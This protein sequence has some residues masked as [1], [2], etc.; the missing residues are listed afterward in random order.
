MIANLTDYERAQRYLSAAGPVAEGG[1]NNA[2][3]RAGYALR[4]NFP[5]LTRWEFESLLADHARAYSP[6]LEGKEVEKTIRSAWQGAESKGVVGAK[7]RPLAAPHG[8]LRHGPRPSPPAAA[9]RPP[10][11]ALE[12]PPAKID[13]A[14]AP[15]RPDPMADGARAFLAAMFAPEEGV[16]ICPARVDDNGREVPSSE[17]T[18]LSCREWLTRLERYRGNPNL[19]FSSDGPGLFVSV[20]PMRL[21]GSRDADVT[22]Y[23]HALL[24]FDK[25]SLDEQWAILAGS[26][27]PL[28]AVTYSGGKSI[29]GLVK[30]NARDRREFDERVR[31]LYAHFAAYLPDEACRNASRFS[32]LPGA[33]R[34]DKRQELLALGM[35]AAGW[36]EWRAEVQADGVGTVVRIEDLEKFD[37]ANDPNA[38]LGRRWLCKGGSA[39]LVG[40]SGVGKSSLTTQFACCL[41]V[42]W[43][44]FGIPP[45]RPLKVLVIQAENDEGDLAEMLAGVRAGMGLDEWTDDAAAVATLRKN[46]VFVRDTTHTG[47]RFVDAAHRLIARHKPDV[48]FL[49]PLLS[50]VGGDISKQE[51]CSAFLRE[52]L[53]PIAEATGVCWICIHHTGKPPSD[54]NARAGWQSSDYAYAGIGSSELTNWARAA[55][56]LRQTGPGHF[57]LM[58]AKRGARAGATH[59]DGEPTTVLWLR[60]ATDGTICWEQCQPPEGATED[61]TGAPI[62][63]AGAAAG[64][65]DGGRG[66]GGKPARRNGRPS[67]TENALAT[68]DFSDWIG[69]L[70]ADGISRRA[71]SE[72]LSEYLAARRVDLSPESIR[73]EG[74]LLSAMLSHGKVGKHGDRFTRPGSPGE[75]VGKNPGE[76]PPF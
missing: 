70:P 61:E 62:G 43:P 36:S 76:K 28:S 12:P 44:F 66:A 51:V 31:T 1:R 47:A 40:P 73:K 3:N 24:E 25:I 19:I 56:T 38:L 20:N 22:E 50:F 75:T 2:L 17:G 60:H 32:R 16:R 8:G 53:N 52:G 29:H 58:L 67:A 48:V 45:V 30:I 21:G 7:A 13:T 26:R 18:V 11:P 23:R 72:S 4:E 64:G 63:G 41:A 14:G 71:A 49:D 46:L 59:P 65:G 10:A 55:L 33:R 57:Q 37:P 27:V 34:F 35:G 68:V 5:G 42:G 69:G 74:G 39:I 54:K 15:A 9:A 6:P